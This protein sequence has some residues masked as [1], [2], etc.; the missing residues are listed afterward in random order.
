M[1]IGPYLD[2]RHWWE[3]EYGTEYFDELVKEI[4]KAY[5]DPRLNEEYFCIE[6][7]LENGKLPLFI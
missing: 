6:S 2:L 7:N 4:L 5:L 3:Y 1:Q